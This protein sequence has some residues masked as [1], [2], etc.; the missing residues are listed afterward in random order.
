MINVCWGCGALRA[1][2]II[3][4]QTSEA[5]CPEC[6]HRHP[7]VRSPLFLVGGASGCGKSAVCRRMDAMRGEVVWYDGD[8]L[9]GKHFEDDGQAFFET[10]LRVCKNTAQAGRPVVLFGAGS[11]VPENLETCLER[12]YFSTLHYLA[13]TC[14]D[15]VLT[16]RLR[17]R[18]AW[19]ASSSDEYVDTHVRFNRWYR[20]S[21]PG[22]GI[23]LVDTTREG[24]D[25][26]AAR[27]MAWIRER[28]N[29]S[30]RSGGRS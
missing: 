29:Q 4:E 19:R 6:A 13:L 2:K 3:D 20:E 5:I 26:T 11:G 14:D 21:G 10:W 27:V 24:E 22:L 25:E 28:L 30:A 9:W 12:R 7:F 8:I 17:A 23:H 16:E 15:A 1:D 18:P